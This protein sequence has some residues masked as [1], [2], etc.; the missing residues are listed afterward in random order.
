MEIFLSWEWSIIYSFRNTQSNPVNIQI[1]ISHAAPDK[2]K[3]LHHRRKVLL[4]TCKSSWLQQRTHHVFFWDKNLLRVPDKSLLPQ[5]QAKKSYTFGRDISR[6]RVR[7][8][9]S[10]PRMYVAVDLGQKERANIT[11]VMNSQHWMK[12][13]LQTGLA[14]N[15]SVSPPEIR[16]RRISDASWDNQLRALQTKITSQENEYRPFDIVWG[17]K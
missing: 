14:K 12:H 3:R 16:K 9:I 7:D 10:T 17:Y 15:E 8:V 13:I 2:G 5:E 11:S 6:R 4:P 1:N